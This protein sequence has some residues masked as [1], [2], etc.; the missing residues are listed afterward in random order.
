MI[1]HSNPEPIDEP[2][3]A[4]SSNWAAADARHAKGG[5]E[6]H[7]L[8]AAFPS[9]PDAEFVALTNDIR[10]HGQREPAIVLDGMVLDGWHRVKACKVIGIEPAVL[11]FYGDDPAAFVLSKNLHRRHLSASQRAM[12]VAAC[13]EWTPVGRPKN[14]EPGSGFPAP[15]TSAQMAKA[16]DVTNRTIRQA[17]VVVVKAV[18]E[19]QEKVKA[20]ELS[21]KAAADIAQL[22]PEEQVKALH[23]PKLRPLPAP[24][25]E[26]APAP[27]LQP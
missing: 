14:P 10:A 7:P 12:A 25:L 5:L 27:A 20:G 9:M 22:P 21:V 24:K 23:A 2:Q 26:P 11:D 3:A 13:A 18:P 17:K 1:F 16:A 6:Q 4:P 8:S 15:M 19:V